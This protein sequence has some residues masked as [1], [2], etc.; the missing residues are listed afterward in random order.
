MKAAYAIFP[1]KL[2]LKTM[3]YPSHFKR[4]INRFMFRFGLFGFTNM[5]IFFTRDGP[6]LRSLAASGKGA[7]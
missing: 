1:A 3:G 7:T 6:I 2:W 5:I 4:K